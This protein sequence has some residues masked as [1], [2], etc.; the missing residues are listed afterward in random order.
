M[1]HMSEE[2]F[3]TGALKDKGDRRDY[4]LSS[5][6]API[7]LPPQVFNL[8][9]LFPSKNQGVRPSC[10]SFAQVHHKERQEKI[11]LCQ[12]FVM[13]LTKHLE[14]N[15]DWGATTR[16]TFVIVQKY[17]V[18]SSD[19]WP[20]PEQ[21]MGWVEYVDAS[22]IPADAYTDA[23]RHKSKSFWRVDKTIE[24][25]RVAL[26]SQKMSIVVSM[27]WHRN[28]NRPIAGLLSMDKGDFVGGHAV[29]LKGFDDI[30]RVLIFKN[31]WGEGWG[32]QGDFYMPYEM[33]DEVVWDLWLSNDMDS[34]LP[35]DTR[36][37]QPRTWASYM[38][39]KSVAF[40]PWLIKE[41]GRLPNN[42]EIIGLAY[43]FWE[44]ESVCKARYGD[45][46]TRM[47]KPEAIKQGLI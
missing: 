38:R 26:V 29:E 36:Y 12:R 25:V 4:R 8:D 18:P 34:V 19:K 40:N 5:V 17:G 24:A 41:I 44:M 1:F 7:E 42:R 23:V 30:K 20:E 15:T 32:Y 43:G 33:F 35:V 47:T 2:L 11:P 13:A 22:K 28:F 39:E 21:G 6:T 27:A 37:G 3:V 14:G 46:W 31:S 16:N 45:L 10:T 9:D